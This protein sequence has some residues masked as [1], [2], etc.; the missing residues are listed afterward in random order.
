[1]NSSLLVNNILR[2]IVLVLAQVI[3][4]DHI[5]FSNYINPYPYL[6]FILLYP[7]NS[8]K[9][10][11][12]LAGFILG[13]CVDMFRDSGGIHAAASVI[14]AYLR[15][16]FFRFSF[17][18]NYEY[19]TIKINEKITSERISFLTI[20]ILTHHLVLFT[21]EFFSFY[22]ILDIILRTLLSSVATLLCSLLIIY[23]FK[24]GK[25]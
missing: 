6:L 24:P 20:S 21:L 25:K 4:F 7:V 8:N 13:L 12:I 19:Q 2:F 15:P 11:L 1:M 18:L 17:G 9:N 5:Q 14:L 22:F 16:A 3:L 10:G 23:S